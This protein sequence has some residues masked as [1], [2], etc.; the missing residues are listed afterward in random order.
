M[1]YWLKGPAKNW[2]DGDCING[3]EPMKGDSRKNQSGFSSSHAILSQISLL[4][5]LIAP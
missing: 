2:E 4:G 5:R 1:L 3:R